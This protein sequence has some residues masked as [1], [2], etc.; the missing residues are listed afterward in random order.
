MHRTAVD[1]GFY[2]RVCRVGHSSHSSIVGWCRGVRSWLVDGGFWVVDLRLVWSSSHVV[3]RGVVVG[4]GSHVNRMVG[5]V[6]VVVGSRVTVA[7]TFLPG[8]EADLWDGD[9]IAGHQRI[10]ENITTDS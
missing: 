5:G 2:L 9:R 4:G 7:V 3:D 1:E 6:V 8:I 10:A